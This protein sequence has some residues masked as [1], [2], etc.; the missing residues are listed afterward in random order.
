MNEFAKLATAFE[1]I[2]ND[3]RSFAVDFLT[4][5]ATALQKMQELIFAFAPFGAQVLSAALPGLDRIS[6]KLNEFG[7]TGNKNATKA[8]KELSKALVG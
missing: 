6:D 2:V 4:P 1:D 5:I 3:I 8:K 7:E